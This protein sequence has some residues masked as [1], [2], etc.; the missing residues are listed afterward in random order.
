MAPSHPRDAPGARAERDWPVSADH[1]FQRILLDNACG[2]AGTTRSRSGPPTRTRPD[3]ARRAMA[4]GRAAIAG[5]ADLAA[6]NRRS[7]AWRG[8]APAAFT[9]LATSDRLRTMSG[10]DRCQARTRSMPD[11]AA[12]ACPGADPS[13]RT[14]ASLGLRIALC[15]LW[16]RHRLPRL[17]APRPFTEWVQHRKLH[18][19]DPRLPRLADKLLA[20]AEVARL[21]GP[22]WVTPTWWHGT[23]CPPPR[24][25]PTPVRRQEPPRLQP[26]AI[27]P[28]RR[29]SDWTAVRAGSATRWMADRYG[30]WL[31][32][33]LYGEIER[34]LLVEP[35]IGTPTL[36]RDLPIDYKLHVFGGRVTLVQVHLEREIA[37]RWLVFDRDWRPLDPATPRRPRRPPLA[38]RDDRRRRDWRT[39]STTCAP[40]STKS[41]ARRRFGELTFY[42]G[43]GLSPVNP[44]RHWK[45][46]WHAM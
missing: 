46:S 45:P 9:R 13:A 23:N 27:R 7:L 12:P 20:K 44:T 38:A 10:H 6:L 28:R 19:R 37:H 31:D 25:W 32:E 40:T 24:L 30:W 39:T 16:C 42:P 17:A 33:W 43:S 8:K 5:H 29:A 15:Y 11:L 2:A 4:L 36:W 1:C 26:D 35:F 21:L 34:G 3:D 18:D 14:T 22:E 41:T